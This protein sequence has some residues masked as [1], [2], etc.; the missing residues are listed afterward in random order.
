MGQTPLP[1][2][3]YVRKDAWVLQLAGVQESAAA[4]TTLLGIIIATGC[5]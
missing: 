2:R 4:T 1:L 5:G 3:K